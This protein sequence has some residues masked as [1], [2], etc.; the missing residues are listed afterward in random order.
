[1]VAQVCGGEI[2]DIS[3]RLASIQ[4]ELASPGSASRWRLSEMKYARRRICSSL[5][6]GAVAE[7]LLLLLAFVAFLAAFAGDFFARVAAF[8]GFTPL[9]SDASPGVGRAPSF[10]LSML[11]VFLGTAVS[12]EVIGLALAGRFARNI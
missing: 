5:G 2:S 8:P 7:G 6:A 12:D 10:C 1:M 9:V 4:S 3:C 11:L